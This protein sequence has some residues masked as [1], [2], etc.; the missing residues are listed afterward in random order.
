MAIRSEIKNSFD[1][2]EKIVHNLV[3]QGD[4]FS[5]NVL[6]LRTGKIDSETVNSAFRTK[7]IEKHYAKH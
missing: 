5:F 3:K 1:K 2:V 7:I 6:N 4:S